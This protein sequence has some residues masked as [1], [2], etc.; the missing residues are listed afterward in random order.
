M[1]SMY[2]ASIPPILRA[3]NNLSH[4]LNKGEAYANAK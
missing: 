2:D 4:I 1:F 3:L